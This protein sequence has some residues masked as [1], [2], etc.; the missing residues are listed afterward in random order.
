ML[1]VARSREPNVLVHVSLWQWGTSKRQTGSFL[2]P[3][4]LS[5]THLEE[6]DKARII[7]K[8]VEAQEL[9]APSRRR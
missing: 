7:Q 4:S 9:E 3:L 8:E 2:R 6:V 1:Q 5:H